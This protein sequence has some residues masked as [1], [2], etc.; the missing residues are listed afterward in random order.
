MADVR[1]PRQQATALHTMNGAVQTVARLRSSA[2][3]SA[4]MSPLAAPGDLNGIGSAPFGFA[5]FAAF[6]SLRLPGPGVLVANGGAEGWQM[7]DAANRPIATRH[8]SRSRSPISLVRAAVA[9]RR[10]QLLV[11][12]SAQANEAQGGANEA[13]QQLAAD[14]MLAVRLQMQEM[15]A[16]R[17]ALEQE[18]RERQRVMLERRRAATR[19]ALT[20]NTA[21]VVHKSTSK[22]HEGDSQQDQ[23]SVCLENFRDGERLRLLPCMHKYHS[24]CI[25]EWFCNSP[26]C[27]VCKHSIIPPGSTAS[28]SQGTV[29]ID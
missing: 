5:N 24:C 8:R 6:P 10:D 3:A 16:R 15:L 29:V 27:P 9:A 18:L 28:A 26:A 12:P 13:R 14:R 17:R 19:V 11:E 1:E 23:C 2:L 22:Q 20:T 21:E 7:G 25:D 4:S